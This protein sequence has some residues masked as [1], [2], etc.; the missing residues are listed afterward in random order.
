MGKKSRNKYL[1]SKTPDGSYQCPHCV[2]TFAQR[3]YIYKHIKG[4]HLKMNKKNKKGRK[5]KTMYEE[6]ECRTCPNCSRTFNSK[7]TMLRHQARTCK[8]VITIKFL[9]CPYCAEEFQ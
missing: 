2:K 5:Q 1:I 8:N 4:V 9:H 7:K 3:Q 6:I